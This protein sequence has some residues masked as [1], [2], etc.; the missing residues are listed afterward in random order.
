M[1]RQIRSKSADVDAIRGVI[2]MWRDSVVLRVFPARSHLHDYRFAG[3]G[4]S[5]RL[6]GNT[7][8]LKHFSLH[9]ASGV[10]RLVH[11]QAF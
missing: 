3:G 7:V 2:R 11:A 10:C 8:T 1:E 6:D 4:V 5:W 9:V